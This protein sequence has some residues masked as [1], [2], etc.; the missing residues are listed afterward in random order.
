MVRD[1]TDTLYDRNLYLNV[2]DACALEISVVDFMGGSKRAYRSL[3]FEDDLL[4]LELRSTRQFELKFNLFCLRYG[5][6]VLFKVS[7]VDADFTVCL[8]SERLRQMI[9]LSFKLEHYNVI[10]SLPC[11]SLT[12]TDTDL[13]GETSLSF[14]FTRVDIAEA[15]YICCALALSVSL[16]PLFFSS[17]HKILIKEPTGQIEE[18]SDFFDF[19]SKGLGTETVLQVWRRD[20]DTYSHSMQTATKNSSDYVGRVLNLCLNALHGNLDVEV[21]LRKELF[22]RNFTALDLVFNYTLYASPWQ[23]VR[24]KLSDQDSQKYIYYYR[25]A[26][27]HYRFAFRRSLSWTA[28]V[29][30]CL[31]HGM[32]LLSTPSDVE[33]RQV[34][35]LL[36]IERD[37]MLL[38][39]RTQLSYLGLEVTRVSQIR[40]TCTWG[41]TTILLQTCGWEHIF[42]F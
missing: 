17:L 8:S 27:T 7:R 1:N 10:H 5:F 30:D 34:S 40:N 36:A 6:R 31:S 18:V 12:I 35:A 23:P 33:W 24:R 39:Q 37:L 32:R 15:K 14:L 29:T 42:S 11:A 22:V 21:L 20:K 25:I 16:A 3:D 9:D 2:N 13:L 19:G 28:A 41:C 26:N 4:V 38:T